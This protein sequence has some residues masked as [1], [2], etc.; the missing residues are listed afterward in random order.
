MKVM[1]LE[2]TP[3]EINDIRS[4]GFFDSLQV[5]VVA[6]PVGE[7]STEPP[8]V[9]EEPVVA[10]IGELTEEAVKEFFY[11]NGG[12]TPTQQ[13]VIKAVYTDGQNGINSREIAKIIDQSRDEVK[14]SMRT[15]GKRKK[16]TNGWPKDV[17][18]L[19]GVWDG[20]KNTYMLN[21]LIREMLDNGEVD[22]TI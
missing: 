19:P 18:V 16:H 4:L 15:I 9:E 6:N 2:G 22:F 1:V 3:K 8:T 10:P 20:V 11:R 14:A 21:P 5:T 7:V 12:M 17:K 13:M